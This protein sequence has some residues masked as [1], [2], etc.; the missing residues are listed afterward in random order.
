M[1]LK[2]LQ[3]TLVS[4]FS[5]FLSEISLAV[6]V[7]CLGLFYDYFEIQFISVLS[8]EDG[9][10]EKNLHK[11]E[12]TLNSLGVALVRTRSLQIDKVANLHLSEMS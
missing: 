1:L 7:N 9:K 12:R 2:K 4:V 8:E 11:K 3:A 10:F 5:M 6:I